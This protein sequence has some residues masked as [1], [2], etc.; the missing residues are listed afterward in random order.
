MRDAQ[1]FNE[2]LFGNSTWGIPHEVKLALSAMLGG[3]N[4]NDD[5][6]RLHENIYSTDLGNDIK[7]RLSSL[8][9]YD[10]GDIGPQQGMQNVVGNEPVQMPP[11]PV[12]QPMQSIRAPEP[13][14]PMPSGPS[15]GMVSM[16][17]R[18]P[19]HPGMGGGAM[20]LVR[21]LMNM[22]NRG[23][24]M[25]VQNRMPEPAYT[26]GTPEPPPSGMW[27]GVGSIDP[28]LLQEAIGRLRSRN[29]G[30]S[31]ASAGPSPEQAAQNQIRDQR[32]SAAGRLARGRETNAV[33]GWTNEQLSPDSPVMKAL[34][35]RMGGA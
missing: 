26:T 29:G 20:E 31:M 22:L 32:R 7:D 18:E 8:F 28:Q 33:T 6:R 1:A 12:Q 13:R 14:Q 9:S 11:E 15:G 25:G 3:A 16:P 23:G 2:L 21:G 5:I 10:S 19:Q 34:I 4:T 30:P 35:A 27:G 24:G 17:A